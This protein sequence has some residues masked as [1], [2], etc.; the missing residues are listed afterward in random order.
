MEDSLHNDDIEKMVVDW[1]KVV[2]FFSIR[3]LVA[4]VVETLV[5]IDRG[6]FIKEN[7]IDSKVQIAALFDPKISPRNL[8]I[9]SERRSHK[10]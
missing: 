7:I 6:L 8:A 9:I 3:L 10:L 2:L 4:N 5:I 1:Y